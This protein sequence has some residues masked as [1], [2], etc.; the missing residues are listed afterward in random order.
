MAAA[1]TT[2]SKVHVRVLLDATHGDH[3]HFYQGQEYD[4]DKATA[5]WLLEDERVAVP[6]KSSGK[7]ETAT[8]E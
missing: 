8:E 4:V 7:T 5:A 2:S 1:K 6:V 3:G